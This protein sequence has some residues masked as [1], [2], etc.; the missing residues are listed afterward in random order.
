MKR[1][2]T[3]KVLLIGLSGF[4]SA[5]SFDTEPIRY[6]QDI[7]SFCKM[8]VMDKKFGCEIV[9]SKGKVFKFDDLS[10]MIKYMKTAQLHEADCKHVVIN[11]Y[12]NPGEFIAYNQA[13]FVK[14]VNLQSPMLGNVAAFEKEIS[15]M[16]FVKTD[17]TA[18]NITWTELK[19]TFE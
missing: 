7:C 8:T 9:T 1:L 13:L 18:K 4:V 15:A 11:S 6:G 5:C 14:T 16:S 17:S 19:D 10:C 3:L 12:E 2:K